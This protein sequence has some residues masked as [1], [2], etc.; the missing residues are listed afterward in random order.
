ML[1]KM[2]LKIYFFK[3]M[4]LFTIREWFLWIVQVVVGQLCGS[5]DHFQPVEA[6][7]I[8]TNM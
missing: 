1:L 6:T 5:M 8:L 7:M 3:W 4:I 2:G